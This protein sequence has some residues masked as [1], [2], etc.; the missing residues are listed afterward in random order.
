MTA[1]VLRRVAIFVVSV[2]V[3]SIVVFL[4]MA[5]LPGDPAQVALGVNATPELLAKTRA[6]FG[7]DR[8]LVTQYFDW[9]GGVLHGDFGRSYV[10]RDTIGPQ[11]L[12]RLGVTLWLVGAGMLVALVIA[13]PAGHV[14][15]GEA[16]EGGRRG[17]FRAVADRRRDPRVPRR[18]HPGADLRRAAALAAVRWVDATG[19]G[20]RRVLPRA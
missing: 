7:I 8:P 2:L 10:T 4:F 12:D 15:R 19:P 18:D 9:I 11:L 5:V 14:R 20:L 3:A 6:E 13:I 1:R 17:R 16:P